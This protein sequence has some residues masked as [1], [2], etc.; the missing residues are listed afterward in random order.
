MIF[1]S[2]WL[3]WHG[4]RTPVSAGDGRTVGELLDD[5]DELA[6]EALLDM[7]AD[8]APGMVRAWPHL[9][10]STV[11]LWAVL[12]RDPTV[13]AKGD[14]MDILGAM[15]RAV[16]RSLAAGHWPGRAQRDEGW[17]QIASNFVQA[18][19]LLQQQP[20]ASEAVANDGP[21]GPTS[22]KTQI[23]HALYITAHATVVALTS[24]ERG[25]QH[26]VEVGA[27]RRQPFVEL[28]TK[29]EVESARGMIARFDAIEQLT[30]GS[31]A[32]RRLKGSRPSGKRSATASH[33]L[34]AALASWRS[35]RT[36]HSPATRTQPIWYGS[37]ACRR[38]SLLQSW[39][40]WRKRLSSVCSPSLT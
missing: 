16:G 23:L 14:P 37:P 13:S 4:R 26:R 9:M 17:E 6:R 27:R 22:A 38:S 28:P 30:A 35:K 7:S 18:R 31:M 25:L 34:E 40:K 2:L 8:R 21:A 11:E 10:Q 19:H 36:A 24:F 12:P 32:A 3:T 33:G 1:G 29:L 39:P 5:S 20:L 15:G